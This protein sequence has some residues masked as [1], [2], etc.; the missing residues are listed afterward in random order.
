MKLRHRRSLFA[1]L[2]V[3][4]IAVFAIGASSASATARSVAGTPVAFKAFVD[5]GFDGVLNG[6][7][8]SAINLECTSGDST[9]V[10]AG[11]ASNGQARTNYV[12]EG[13]NSPTGTL[14]PDEVSASADDLDSGE[15]LLM[16]DGQIGDEVSGH[17]WF[18]NGAENR[19]MTVQYAVEDG[20]DNSTSDCAVWGSIIK[21]S[22]SS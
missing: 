7:S 3:G 2:A 9:L 11:T 16:N 19:T 20:P 6:V 21:G 10:L 15:F 1:V 13:S 5:N 4:I 12:E 8:G 22:Y 17:A 18:V 14:N